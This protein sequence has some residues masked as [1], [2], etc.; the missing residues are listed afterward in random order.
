MQA[1]EET[2][3]MSI[4]K[5]RRLKLR[6]DLKLRNLEARMAGGKG[7]TEKQHSAGKLTARERIE[8]LFDAGTFVEMDRFRIHQCRSFG[9]DEKKFLGDG[10][11]SG[12]G[13]IDGRQ[14]FIYAQDFTIFG[15]SLSKTVAEK[16]CKIYDLAMKAGVPVI[17]LADSGG[18]RIQEGVQSLAGYAE[19][20]CRNTLASGLIPQISVVMGPSAGGA[21]YSPALTDFILMVRDT[22]YMFLTG[23][24]VI[25]TVTH[26]EVSKE[27]LG[28]AITHNTKS[29][30]AHFAFDDDSS[31]LDALRTLLSYLPSNNAEE[32]PIITCSDDPERRDEK[33]KIIVPSKPNKPYDVREIIECVIDERNFFEIQQ[34][35]A[36]N[37]VIGFARMQGKTIGIV[38]NQPQ[39]LAGA[40]DINASDKAARFVR[41]CDCFNIPIIT[42]VDVPGFLPGTAQEYGGIIRHGAKLLYAYAEATVPKITIILR[43][44][45]GGAYCVMGPK[46][47]RADLNFALPTAEIAV[48]GADGAVNIVMREELLAATNKEDRLQE[49]IKNYREQFQN[50]YRA[51][52][53]GY[54]DEVILPEDMRPRFCQALNLLRDKRDQLPTKKH[55]NIPL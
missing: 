1:T 15:G 18:A 45:Y 21:V 19:I 48:M 16:I 2:H 41:F 11:V 27:E 20:F 9:M 23:P 29:G 33:L 49:L 25:K 28:G 39:I 12:F 52:E 35:F 17:G 36:Q 13:Q 22:S 5:S 34:H 46:H 42:F 6:E 24:D 47:L 55:G 31:A 37:I 44:A 14:I 7:R 43:K 51:A 10:L 30:V 50:P 8:L 40:I 38:A 3:V 26:E 32:P 4:K 54:I 53:L